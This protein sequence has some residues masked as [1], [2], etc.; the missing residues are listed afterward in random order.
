MSQGI[1]T[2]CD[3]CDKLV[4]G[5]LWS[6]KMIYHHSKRVA[7]PYCGITVKDRGLKFH[8][9]RCHTEGR[10]TYYC[11]KCDKTYK[12]MTQ[13]KFHLVAQ[14]NDTSQGN[15]KIFTCEYCQLKVPSSSVLEKHIKK[16]HGE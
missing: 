9:E 4:S 10:R 7:C 16:V 11:E 15:V 14:H 6:H 1:G 3:I 2:K 12:D 13:F 5:G 8:I